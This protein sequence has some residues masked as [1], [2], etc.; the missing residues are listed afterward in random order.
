MKDTFDLEG[1]NEFVCATDCG[2]CEADACW[3]GKAVIPGSGSEF[4][5]I[6]ACA[7]PE[8][9]PDFDSAYASI[10]I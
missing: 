10:Y 3:V 6:P 1:T 9:T 2:N 8:R 5:M 7:L 4:D